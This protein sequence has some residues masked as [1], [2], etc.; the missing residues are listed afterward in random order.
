MEL[1]TMAR[2]MCDASRRAR[3]VEENSGQNFVRITTTIMNTKRFLTP[4]TISGFDLA[5]WILQVMDASNDIQDGSQQWIPTM[6][7]ATSVMEVVPNFLRR[8]YSTQTLRQEIMQLGEGDSGH[9]GYEID[10]NGSSSSSSASSDFTSLC[11]FVSRA[12]AKTGM[13][14]ELEKAN[15]RAQLTPSMSNDCDMEV[16]EGEITH[17]EDGDKQYQYRL[18]EQSLSRYEGDIASMVG[19][20]AAMFVRGLNRETHIVPPYV[21]C[22]QERTVCSSLF[23]NSYHLTRKTK[24]LIVIARISK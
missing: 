18:V 11:Y 10:S 2:C 9:S 17:D 20:P 1:A 14:I 5:N 4:L 16:G 19:L 23:R 15:H 12:H 13:I 8:N 7:L 3:E 6:L 22:I 21:A 24:T